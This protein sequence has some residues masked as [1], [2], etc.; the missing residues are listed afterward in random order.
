MVFWI[1]LLVVI[2][3]FLLLYLGLPLLWKIAPGIL[4]GGNA[5][6]KPSKLDK[7]AQPAPNQIQASYPEVVIDETGKYE[8]TFG[9]GR[10]FSNGILQVHFRGEWYH[11]HP[12][13]V[14]KALLL[15]S[16][17]QLESSDSLGSFQQTIMNWTLEG[18]SI[19][20]QTSITH[21][22]NQPLI[23]FQIR[24]P[25]GLEAVS[26]NEFKELIFRFPCFNLEGPNQRILAY[27]DVV[28]C[29]PTARIPKRGVQG[30]VVFFDNEL[31]A[32]V[33]GPTEHFLIA[34]TQQR[35]IIYHGFEGEIKKIPENYQHTSLLFFTKGINKAIVEWCGF[36]SKLQNST[37]K[38]PYADPVIANLGFW[39]D[40]GAYYYYRKEKGMNYA[41]TIE[42]A[43]KI[44]KN[45]KIP[46]NYYQLDSWWYQKDMKSFWKFPPFS[47]IGRL[48]GGGAYGG[49]LLWEE[50]PEEFPEGLK[51]L[52]R[53]VS[54]PFACHARWF[55]IKSPYLEKYRCASGKIAILPMEKRFWDDLMKQASEKG[56]IMYEQD[57]LKTTISRIPLLREEVDAIE[58]W[59]TWMAEAASDNKITI[60]YCM[61][62]AGAF[63]YAM[64]LSAVTNARVTGDYHARVTKQF[65]FPHFSQTNI[66][67]WGV[68]IWPS[69][70]CYLTTTTPLRKG[71]YREKY[72]TQVTLLSNL[73]GGIICPAD[74]AELVDRE[75]LLKT[76]TED[77]LLLKPDRPITAND[78]MFKIHQKPYIMDT[79]T[80]KGNL[81]WR[82]I[83]VVNLWPRRVKDSTMTLTELG[84]PETGVLYDFN[85]G[86]LQEIA[87][88]DV[89]KIS[90]KRM[91]YKYFI[92]A[93]LLEEKLAIIGSPDKFVTCANAL[94]PSIQYESNTLELSIKYSPQSKVRLLI[95][96]KIAPTT[97]EIRNGGG[98]LE[99]NF[100]PQEK[101]LL[102][103][104]SFAEKATNE[105]VIFFN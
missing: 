95:Y 83:F 11:S 61:A 48:I 8:I 89:I 41:S 45:R 29:P 101:K 92:F 35:D 59:L 86:E 18:T 3:I 17:K 64:K 100:D 44:F 62:P 28:F 63:L 25:K 96:S 77:G 27:Q 4:G 76:C 97:V 65:Y 39:T 5:A 36:L 71:L 54:L 56:I 1:P 33:F 84:Y 93:P 53:K 9:L 87:P 79:W 102:L 51:A 24:F 23:K 40:N 32:A 74:K 19:P 10:K 69:L 88:N 47:W 103:I 57:W 46:F 34:Y 2:L 14:N 13:S 7:I 75:L 26:T 16:S 6:Y 73:G 55:S 43:V 72:P 38:N 99:W 37:P 90:L 68:G 91:E 22:S 94:V 67:V 104:I 70:D 50:I 20:I 12:I 21:Y 105:I 49:T 30:P 98:S 80:Q 82:Y 58:N 52:H 78:L 66:L 31:N 15:Q 81:I 85:T 42:Y 60:Q